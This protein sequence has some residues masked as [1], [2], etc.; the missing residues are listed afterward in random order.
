[1]DREPFQ[2][3]G[4]KGDLGPWSQPGL[5]FNTDQYAGGREST[6]LE[7]RLYDLGPGQLL[8]CGAICLPWWQYEG[9][10]GV[11]KAD[12][13]TLDL[14]NCQAVCLLKAVCG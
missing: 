8:S 5:C 7:G 9:R 10:Q 4:R 3:E 13:A 12:N 1:M 6:E 2:L 11:L 14:V